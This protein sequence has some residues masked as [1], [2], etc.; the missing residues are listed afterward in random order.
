M[1]FLLILAA[2]LTLFLGL[3]AVVQ[4]RDHKAHRQARESEEMWR[5]DV[6][7]QARDVRASHALHNIYNPD[8]SWTD[9]GRRN[10]REK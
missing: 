6:R 1:L 9:W 4:F 7:E 10:R 2:F 8:M 3:G 5:T